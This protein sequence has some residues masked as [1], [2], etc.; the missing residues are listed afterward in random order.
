MLVEI[1][2][3]CVDFYT[4]KGLLHAV[5]GIS[6]GLEGGEVLG[7]VGESGS[8]KSVTAH[9]ILRLL[10]GN[11]VVSGG[12]IRYDGESVLGMSTSRLRR[13]RGG[14]VGI[15][16]QEPSR[17]FDPIYSVGN[18]LA[19]TLL[20]HYPEMTEAEVRERSIALLREVR[21]P[22]PEDRLGNY[23]H[24]FS[25]G[26]LQRIM[27]ALAL[28]SNP[29]VLIADE[30]T[31]ALDVTIQAEIIDLLLT[32]K[33]DR[34]LS[35][36]FITHNLSLISSIADRMV[37]M[38]G[39]LIM[40]QGPAADILAKPTHDYTKY[41]LTSILKFG[42]H[43][44]TRP[45]PIFEREPYNPYSEE[46]V[47]EFPQ[48]VATLDDA[49]AEARLERDDQA[50]AGKEPAIELI[51]VAKR[52]RLDAGFF[53]PVGRHVYAVN[54][55]NFAI[56]Q[57]EVYGLVGESGCGKTTTA[58]LIVRMLDATDGSILF[59]E[60]S[61]EVHGIGDA[62]KNEIRYVRNRIKY[63][64]QDP[65]KSLNPR[66]SVLDVLTAGYRH[67]PDW[68]GKTRARDEAA[69]ILE[70]VGLSGDDLDRRPGDFSGGQRQR[71]AIAR[72][73]ITQPEVL[74][75]D[76]VVSAL[77]V[78]IQGQ[79]LNLLLQVKETYGLSILFIAHDL[80]VVSYIADRVGVMYRGI[81]VEEAPAMDL[82]DDRLHPYTRH[83]YSSIP[84]LGDRHR[85]GTGTGSRSF[86]AEY[87]PTV[88]PKAEGGS[89]ADFKLQEVAP[90]HRIAKAYAH[91]VSV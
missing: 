88:D 67:S 41:L 55:L 30:P 22:N 47:L 87:D 81:L 74:I 14:Q 76:E 59:R 84:R 20:V 29:R 91:P 77:D 38:Y 33:E 68:P 82:I 62:D 66:M 86:A 69:A 52:Y 6:F 51:D 16:F 54:G 8:G 79:I 42:D 85:V 39:G 35:I 31:T 12:D 45:I 57:G 24:Q 72:A 89:V 17:S 49:L 32:L 50:V 27:I 40:E 10:P 61:G 70:D 60:R 34:D 7:I 80:A 56:R 75:C 83:L 9:T 23:P 78:S 36:V 58:R 19:E 3:L 28:A 15:I 46:P 1:E 73:L 37:V 26:M 90:G 2:N 65:A 5:R 44:T 71:I 18:A 43:H 25:G 53:A 64:F 13:Y 21:I 63:V 4:H 11:G 48:A